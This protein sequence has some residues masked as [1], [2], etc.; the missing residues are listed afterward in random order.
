MKPDAKRMI[1]SGVTDGGAGDW[2]GTVGVA[3]T[4][5]AISW[6]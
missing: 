4:V 1:G 5:M 2:V 3:E 6:S